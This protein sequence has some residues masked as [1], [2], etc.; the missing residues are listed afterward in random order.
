V[1][2]TFA[3]VLAFVLTDW[4]RALVALAAAGY[5]LMN[6]K[7]SSSDLLKHVDGDLMLLLFGLFILNAALAQT[8]LPV[9]LLAELR[10]YGFDLDRPLVLFS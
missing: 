10:R 1:A 6:R 3:V 5:L 9:Q 2:V 8:D 4:P 7:V